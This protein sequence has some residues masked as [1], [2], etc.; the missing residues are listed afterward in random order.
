VTPL[1]QL[2]AT[3]ETLPPKLRAEILALGAAAVPDLIAIVADD[4]ADADDAPGEGWPPIHA[5]ELLVELRAVEAI[6][7]MLDVVFETEIEDGLHVTVVRGLSELGADAVLAPTLRRLDEAVDPDV[8]SSLLEI[9][10]ALGVKDERIYDAIGK[11]FEADPA[12]GAMHFGQYG[13][14]R[15]LPRLR[16][17]IAALTLDTARPDPKALTRARSNM[18]DL[19]AAHQ[20]LGGVLEGSLRRHVDAQNAAWN[21]HV[22]RERA[23]NAPPKVGRNDP[24]TCGSGKK[25]K[26]CCQDK[27]RAAV[28]VG[29]DAD[30][31]EFAR[32]L[33]E[34]TDGSKREADG[35]LALAQLLWNIAVN[36]DAAGREEMIAELMEGIPRPERP[37]FD[38][39]ARGM[40]E[41]YRLGRAD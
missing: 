4:D 14:P 41:R 7:T 3:T 5:V 8:T 11:V 22:T 9:L 25:Y 27:A 12:A 2:R 31:A 16:E 18:L 30:F 13:D 17:R 37:E 39:L 1:E 24:C 35:A 6:E 40:V 26:K 21:V 32:P 38:A 34:S 10:T 23:A 20:R 29:G 28:P 19:L 15:A 36:P 33:L